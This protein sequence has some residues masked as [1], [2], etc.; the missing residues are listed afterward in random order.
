MA[1]LHTYTSNRSAISEKNATLQ[2]SQWYVFLLPTILAITTFITYIPSL[3]YA[4]HFDDKENILKYFDIRHASIGE[5]FFSS[6]RWISRWLNTVYYAFG[7]FNPF[8]YRLAG[9]VF[10]ITTGI[11]L[12][13]LIYHS[14]KNQKSFEP[15][16]K[17]AL[18]CATITSMLFLLH[19]VQTQTVSYIIQGQLEGLA[20]LAIICLLLS[21]FVYTGSTTFIQKLVSLFAII[22]C[23]LTGCGT[24]EIFIVAP[25]LVVSFDWFFVAQGSSRKCISRIWIYA[26]ISILVTA[27]FYYFST[28]AVFT[29]PTEAYNNFGNAITTQGNAVI[30]RYQFFI[31]QFKV[32]LHYIFMFFW[33]FGMSVD[34]DWKLVTNFFAFDC[35]APLASLLSLLIGI[36]FVLKNNKINFF[37]FGAL[38]FFTCILPRSS[39]IPSCELL[40][41]YKTYSASIGIYFIIALIVVYA[42]NYSKNYFEKY[43]IQ[44]CIALLFVCTLLLSYATY[45]RNLVWSTEEAFWADIITKAPARA[46]GHNNYGTA[47]QDT[48]NHA[49]ACTAFLKA[50]E[51][52]EKYPDPWIN[53]S[54]SYRE[55]GNIDKA[56]EC[57]EKAITLSKYHPEAYLNYGLFLY[58]KKRNDEAEQAF[59]KAI[60][61]RPHYGK[62]WNNLSVVRADSGNFKGACEAAKYAAT[63]T[64]FIQ[65]QSFLV[66]GKSAL[67][68]KKYDEAIEAF[69]AMLKF[70]PDSIDAAVQLAQ[71]YIL[72]KNYTQAL[73]LYTQVIKVIP[74]NPIFWFNIGECYKH[75][76]QYQDAIDAYGNTIKYM[77]MPKAELRIAECYEKLG[78]IKEARTVLQN[79]IAGYNPQGITQ[80]AKN[81]LL[82]L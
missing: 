4:F 20:T 5:L 64:D 60:T 62:A 34:Y 69:S 27:S 77:N 7:E 23:T 2:N 15:V 32:I 68:L 29:I 46:R 47:L 55:L 12:F 65:T 57:I 21:F 40:A 39:I 56:I 74:N 6:P 25:V 36:L 42:L 59:S 19:P 43:Y 63:K 61:L 28:L 14:N 81:M 22:V 1:I 33:P 48:G 3:F 78:N 73:K 26:L 52:D 24:K 9:I 17:Y 51:L 82:N 37:A 30:G 16:R 18:V 76:A 70:N 80:Q 58:S 38:W 45:K 72:V 53:L 79:I 41:D 10:H 50:I 54:V 71:C 31:S 67:E 11:A 66:W 13:A 49:A 75:L 35:I 8:V 44:A